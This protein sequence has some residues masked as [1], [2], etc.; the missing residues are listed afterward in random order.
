LKFC[1]LVWFFSL[2]IGFTVAYF[3]AF[4]VRSLAG[5]MALFRVCAIPFWTSNVIRMISWSGNGLVN[6][7]FRTGCL[8]RG[9]P[10][11]CP[12]IEAAAYPARSGSSSATGSG[13]LGSSGRRPRRRKSR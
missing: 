6:S 11:T 8:A 9:P 1:F 5:Q 12:W 3:L 10:A 2:V 4:H 13:G 7:H